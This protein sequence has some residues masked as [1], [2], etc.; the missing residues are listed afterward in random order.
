[1]EFV[2][3]ECE[4]NNN[5]YYYYT[6]KTK[7]DNKYLLI[8][9]EETNI[10]FVKII[11]NNEIRYING[12]MSR[13][14]I[15]I[16][17][18]EEYYYEIFDKDN[19]YVNKIDFMK[20]YLLIN[21]SK[22]TIPS[23]IKTNMK[24]LF[25]EP[26]DFKICNEYLTFSISTSDFNIKNNQTLN[27]QN[28]NIDKNLFKK[29][30][31]ELLTDVS[32]KVYYERTTRCLHQ[33]LPI[34]IE[35]MININE[36][37]EYYYYHLYEEISNFFNLNFLSLAT[38]TKTIIVSYDNI[39]NFKYHNN[40]KENNTYNLYLINCNHDISF[41]IKIPFSSIKFYKPNSF[42]SFPFK[43][44]KIQSYNIIDKNNE[45]KHKL[46][47][48]KIQEI[49]NLKTNYIVID[50]SENSDSTNDSDSDSDNDDINKKTLNDKLNKN[51]NKQYINEL[52][53]IN[54][55]L[56][57]H[58]QILYNKNYILQKNVNEL[59]KEVDELKNVI[60]S[61]NISDNTNND[62]STNEL[63]NENQQLHNKIKSIANIIK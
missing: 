56:K 48:Q 58:I 59:K 6:N 40:D 12:N 31:T 15:E 37:L 33:I 47:K 44:N 4:E 13:N 16:K 61:N 52:K 35:S 2:K 39:K 63:K 18:Y 57:S 50:I 27:I 60:T 17:P 41:K 3:F 25:F 14:C 49:C 28:I 38:N 62:K 10:N 7:N 23:H 11:V 55:N 21:Y 34:D 45:E 29:S 8:T 26:I 9:I 22:T 43:G 20:N 53:N 46:F 1:M 30:I 51:Q 36:T 5:N 24:I 32:E 42:G 54:E 19:K